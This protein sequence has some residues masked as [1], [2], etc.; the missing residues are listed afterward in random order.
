MLTQLEITS[1]KSVLDGK[2]YGAVGAY[3]DRN[4]LFSGAAAKVGV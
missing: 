4:L 1:R 3:T 2:L